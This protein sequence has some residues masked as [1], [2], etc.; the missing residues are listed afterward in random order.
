MNQLHCRNFTVLFYVSYAVFDYN[1]NYVLNDFIIV[2]YFF[3]LHSKIKYVHATSRSML[4][5]EELLNWTK[6]ERINILFCREKIVSSCKLKLTFFALFYC[7][8]LK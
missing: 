3:F 7:L 4:K 2:T 8:E 6:T 1:S 5:Y